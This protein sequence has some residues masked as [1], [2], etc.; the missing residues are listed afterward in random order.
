M[1]IFGSRLLNHNIY[2]WS[3]WLLVALPFAA[4]IGYALFYSVGWAGW[5][6]QGFTLRHWAEVLYDNSFWL[7]LLFSLY[8]AVC[9]VGFSWLLAWIIVFKSRG[10]I[11]SGTLGYLLFL[12]LAI[13]PIAAALFIFHWL[14]QSGALARIGYHVGLISQ[15]GG[16]P[17]LIHDSWGIGI[18]VTHVLL[19][20]PFFTLLLSN[21][22]RQERMVHL[23]ALGA[24]L[25]ATPMQRI[26]HIVLPL[27]WSR[28]RPVAFLYALFVLG[29]YEIPLLLGPSHPEMLSVLIIR[30]MQRF[31]LEAIPQGMVIALLYVSIVMVALWGIHRQKST[32]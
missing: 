13:P 12:P 17:V 8:V 29:A 10:R 32:T 7:S 9:S 19:A 21:I 16:F 31:S 15:P 28:S 20:T 27:L 4:G 1:K 26:R 23:E 25:G 30:K 3:Y 14:G 11:G 18:I 6:Q 24:T 5:L 22:Y 2:P